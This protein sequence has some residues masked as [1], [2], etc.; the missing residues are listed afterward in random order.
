VS[1]RDL[2]VDVVKQLLFFVLPTRLITTSKIKKKKRKKNLCTRHP[3]GIP[4]SWNV[5]SQ[6]PLFSLIAWMEALLSALF[7]FERRR[8]LNGTWGVG[9]YCGVWMEINGL[10]EIFSRCLARR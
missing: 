8:M 5:W 7:F 6:F 1:S 3:T 4:F 2:P 9:F 10:V